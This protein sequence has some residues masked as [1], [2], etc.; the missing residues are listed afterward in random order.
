MDL[1]ELEAIRARQAKWAEREKAGQ[2]IMHGHDADTAKL[3]A[4]VD[5]LREQREGMIAPW[6]ETRDEHSAAIDAAHPVH[7]GEHTAYMTALKMVGNRRDKYSLVGL[8]NWLLVD[9]A[10]H[11]EVADAADAFRKAGGGA[12]WMQAEA[13]ERALKKAGY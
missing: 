10:K 3:L 9:L 4:Y 11:R 5:E 1:A 6:G 13:L 2:P 8:V 7:T 12:N